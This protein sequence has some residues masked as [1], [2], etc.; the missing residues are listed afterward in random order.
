[1]PG[2]TSLQTNML[3]FKLNHMSSLV[4]WAIQTLAAIQ[5]WPVIYYEGEQNRYYHAVVKDLNLMK[6]I[7]YLEGM[8]I[9]V[10]SL[11]AEL[12][13]SRDTGKGS[14]M[15]I[16]DVIG[17]I[18]DVLA[19]ADLTIT[20]FYEMLEDSGITIQD[21]LEVVNYVTSAPAT[22]AAA[23]KETLAVSSVFYDTEMSQEAKAALYMLRQYEETLA[24]WYQM[25]GYDVKY[26]LWSW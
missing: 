5:F 23:A 12:S 18:S 17:K 16:F 8:G 10:R 1:M 14:S 25:A 15:N 21:I 13:G 7:R 4:V 9:D 24:K 22:P 6:T 20:D 26:N 2:K 19:K 11:A 3:V